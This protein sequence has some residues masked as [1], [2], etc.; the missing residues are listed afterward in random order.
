MR[1]DAQR[2]DDFE[3]RFLDRGLSGE[4]VAQMRQLW[5]NAGNP[6]EG[7][8]LEAS[9]DMSLG[10][11]FKAALAPVRFLLKMRWQFLVSKGE[12]FITGDTPVTKSNDRIR[13]PLA[14]GLIHPHTEVTFPISPSVCFRAWWKRSQPS[15][16]D[17]ADGE[18]ARLNRERV[19]FADGE[20]FACTEAGAQ[21]ALRVCAAL[22]QSGE[23]HAKAMSF[24]LSERDGPPRPI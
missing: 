13:P 21:A 3:R 15:V 4:Q 7:C 17:I 18:V 22:R 2:T 16:V 19:R 5:L 11:A 9:P 20:V 24:M 1:A 23:A 14:P 6:A 12:P 8:T 10:Y